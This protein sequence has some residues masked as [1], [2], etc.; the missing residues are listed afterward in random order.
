MCGV[1]TS[2]VV[3]ASTAAS[4]SR[5]ET[6]C[7]IVGRPCS[8]ASSTT[9]SSVSCSGPPGVTTISVLIA[10]TPASASSATAARVTSG[11]IAPAVSAGP[12]GW[13][14]GSVRAGSPA[15]PKL[16]WESGTKPAATSRGPATSSASSRRRSS[17]ICSVG[18]IADSTLVNPASRN[19]SICPGA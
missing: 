7:V 1:C 6:A 8:S 17:R 19:S 15:P 4:V 2:S 14:A 11:G 3:P 10:S 13:R 16:I 5:T 9:S 18:S 12:P